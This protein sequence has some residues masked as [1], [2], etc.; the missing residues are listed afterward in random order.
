MHQ[1]SADRRQGPAHHAYGGTRMGDNRSTNVVDRWGFAHEVPNL[2]IL[3]ASVMG[4]SGAHNPT[5]TAQ[6]LAWRTAEHLAGN[7]TGIA[8]GMRGR[9]VART[10]T[11]LLWPFLRRMSRDSRL[12]HKS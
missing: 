11:P 9:P 2:D 6:A 3:G 4:T 12:A 7:W 8:G 5:L 10:D 1:G